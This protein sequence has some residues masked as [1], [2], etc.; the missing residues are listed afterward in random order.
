VER[1]IPPGG[2]RNQ[3]LRLINDLLHQPRLTHAPFTDLTP[4][5][6]GGL[7]AFRRR[8][9][10]FLISDFISA[11]GWE[12]PLSLMNRRHEVIAVRLWD[13]REISLPDIGPV[14]MEDAET[15]EQLFV[16]THDRRF[17]QRFE[18]AA[19]QR[20]ADLAQTFKHAGVDA[21]ALSTEEDLVRAI[22]RYATLRKRRRK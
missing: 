3:V 20:E 15:G 5:I 13:P 14:I 16:D 19:R 9:L 8:S 2:G 22:V 21:L 17:R 11:P 12:A 1:V 10:V 6:G 4:L 7:N 18:Q